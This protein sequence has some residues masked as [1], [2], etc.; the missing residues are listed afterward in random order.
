[1]NKNRFFLIVER[2]YK[3][4][5]AKKSF[6]LVTLLAPVL[7]I[8]L[9]L[10]PALLM[11][12]NSSDARLV[13]IVDM[14][15]KYGKN[16]KDTDDYK[17][18]VL[19]NT[20]VNEIKQQYEK[21]DG[22]I[23]A[24]LVIP[25]NVETTHQVNIYSDN[26][27]KMSLNN[28]VEDVL[29]KSLSDAKISSYDIPGLADIIEKS[30]ISVS[31]KS[32]TWD[33]EGESVSSS[34]LSMIIGMA[35][36]MLTYIF[37]LM[38]GAMIMSSVV[39]DK[40]NRIVEVIVSS[41]RPLELMLGKIVSIALV[42][43]T[44][45]AVWS[46]FIGIGLFALSAIGVT[47]SPADT[48]QL[49]GEMTQLPISEGEEIVQAI[50]GVDWGKLLFIFVLYF[51]G[52]YLLYASLFAGFGSAVDQQSDANQFMTPIMM[53]IILA[54]LIGEGCMQDPDGTL[55]VICSFIP[56][57]S[58]I[59]MMIRLPYDVPAWEIATSVLLLYGTALLFTFFASRIYRTGILMYGRK[60]TFKELLKWAK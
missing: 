1:M 3:A 38:Y 15:G 57:T 41:C 28:E 47:S 42:G 23:Y 32:H 52:G 16:F 9:M 27:V 48:A 6:I 17:F 14:S 19:E 22:D 34:T 58:P 4:I 12:M 24:I 31:V 55:G 54:L 44:Q 20:A 37:V 45:I 13:S 29:E 43:L 35:L 25:A 18:H 21:A 30:K 33:E 11:D 2:E 39:E 49:Q 46:V 40:T 53:I 56:F 26:P 8:G 36:A 10:V 50:L 7:M 59:V 5:V 51:I 60:V